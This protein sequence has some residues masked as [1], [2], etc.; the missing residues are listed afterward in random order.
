MSDHAEPARRLRGADKRK[1]IYSGVAG[2]FARAFDRAL[3][4]FAPRTVHAMQVARVRSSALVAY[5][6]ARVTRTN[7]S[8]GGTGS[9]DAEILPDIRRLRDLSR[10]MV[11]DDSHASTVMQIHED[12]IVGE[13]I[14]AQ[15]TCTPESTGL[16]KEACE[17]WNNAC[18]REFDAWAEDTA[19]ATEVGTFYDLQAL[20]LRSMLTDGDGIAHAVIDSDGTIRVELIDADRVESPGYQDTDRIRGGVE[21]GA[22]GERIAYWI[23][24]THPSEGSLAGA[25]AFA[26][27][28]RFPA[29]D[30]RG[31]S[32]VQ[33]LFRRQR[34]GQTRGVPLLTPA[35]M[36]TRQLHHYLDSEVI[37]ARAASNF[38][39]FIKRNVSK[40]DEGILPVEDVESPEAVRW[41]TKLE[42]GLVE[43]L[44]GDEE[45]FAFTPNRPGTAFEPFVVRLLR[46]IC[47]S[48]NLSYE[49]VLRDFGRMNLSSAR[50]MLREIRRGFDLQRKRLIRTFCEPWRRNVLLAAIGRGELVPPARFLDDP[51]PFLACRWVSPV[52]GMV[53]PEKDTA[54]AVARMDAG[55]SDPFEE[56][57][58]NGR[59][60]IEV[61]RAKA[62]YAKA[63]MEIEQEF[64]LPSGALSSNTGTPAPA[65]PPK[66]APRDED[67]DED[68]DAPVDR[69]EDPPATEPEEQ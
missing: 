64:G 6:A 38:A 19:D 63:Q 1:P 2:A 52:Y 43:Y 46:S 68:S 59:D 21:L 25:R 32:L 14:R 41:L 33:Q 48:S 20:L 42:P 23:L 58:I 44:N 27:P 37:A 40:G 69:G 5:E 66:P 39:L 30:D 17:A 7:P 51:R 56:A 35:V 12:C 22:R 62:R 67:D 13:G 29:K 55:L 10:T 57:A 47:A 3:G 31:Y 50:A 34:P 36:L 26:Q 24:S 8:T 11:R 60:A 54:A 53:D 4:V 49:V 65:A 9:A 16:E 28:T 15:S 61:L 45:P 18:E